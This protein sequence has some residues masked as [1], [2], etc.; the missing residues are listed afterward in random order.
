MI[1]ISAWVVRTLQDILDWSKGRPAARARDLCGGRLRCACSRAARTL[2]RAV[3]FIL[4][5]VWSANICKTR[6]RDGVLLFS[7]SVKGYTRTMT[8]SSSLTITRLDL[9]RLEHLLDS[10]DDFGPNAVALVLNLTPQGQRRP[11]R[12]GW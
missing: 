2:D 3:L 10:L 4:A 8:S 6:L 1:R 7:R 12:A 5:V 9:Q 11:C